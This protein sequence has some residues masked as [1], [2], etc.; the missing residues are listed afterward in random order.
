MFFDIIKE[1]KF[2]IENAQGKLEH[3]IQIATEASNMKT[4]CLSSIST[5]ISNL[6]TIESLDIEE[7]T[8]NYYD[9]LR[10]TKLEEEALLKIYSYLKEV[11]KG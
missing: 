11:I 5:S 6:A 8:K 7:A 2:M 9:A 3:V 10:S 4:N 1:R